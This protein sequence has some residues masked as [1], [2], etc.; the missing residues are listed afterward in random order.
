MGVLRE[1]RRKVGKGLFFSEF[2]KALMLEVI[3]KMVP[4]K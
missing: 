1:E 4:K 2:F 3:Y